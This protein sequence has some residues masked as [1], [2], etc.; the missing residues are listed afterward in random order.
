MLQREEQQLSSWAPSEGS[1]HL[2]CLSVTWAGVFLFLSGSVFKSCTFLSV[3]PFLPGC[4][5]Y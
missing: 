3:Y 1:L 2:L 4:P 5:F